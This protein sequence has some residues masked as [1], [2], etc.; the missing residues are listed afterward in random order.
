MS[1]P[2][3]RPHREAIKIKRKEIKKAQKEL[4]KI[5]QNKG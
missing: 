2:S 3:N 4:R 5:Q 1:K